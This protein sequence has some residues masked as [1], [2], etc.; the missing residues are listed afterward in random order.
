MED[1]VLQLE[2]LV[3]AKEAEARRRALL[4]AQSEGRA[5][6]EEEEE[7]GRHACGLAHRFALGLH[8]AVSQE[9]AV[10]QA[11]HG[12]EV[13]LRAEL[14]TLEDREQA[15]VRQRAMLRLAALEQEHAQTRAAFHADEGATRSGLQA[16]CWRQLCGAWADLLPEQA[17]PL[18]LSY[19]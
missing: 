16:E 19:P 15:V 6:L 9:R 5:Q 4:Q 11:V 14:E 10:R 18:P 3:A 2:R 17:C 12:F 13:Q 8:H 7:E 1:H